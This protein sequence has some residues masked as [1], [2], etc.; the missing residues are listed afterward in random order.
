MKVRVKQ[1]IGGFSK[2]Y[3]QRDSVAVTIPKKIVQSLGLND[4]IGKEFFGMVFVETDRGLLLVPFDKDQLNAATFGGA[5]SFMNLS[6]LSK[7]DLD[8]LMQNE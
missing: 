6:K 5:L 1:D 8:I 2:P 4:K 7:E 3:R